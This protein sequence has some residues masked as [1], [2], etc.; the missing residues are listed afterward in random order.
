LDIVKEI[1]EH[2]N[3]ENNESVI[4]YKDEAVKALV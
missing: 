4:I 1:P 2:L 3:E